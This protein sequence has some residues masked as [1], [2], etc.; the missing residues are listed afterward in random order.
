[1]ITPQQKEK[2]QAIISVFETGKADGDPSAVAV[3]SDGA[4]ISYGRHQ[5]TDGSDSLDAIVLRAIELGHPLSA[6]LKHL[7]TKLQSDG[8]TAYRSMPNEK[9]GG[10]LWDA[11]KLLRECGNHPVMLQAQNEVFDSMYWAPCAA[12]CVQMGLI[13]PLSWAVVYDSCIHSGP[14]GVARI[15]ARFA[16]MP[17]SRGGDEKAWVSAYVRERRA[18][19][20]GR[21]GVVAKT[22]YRMDAF[23]ALIRDENWDL[24]TPFRVRGVVINSNLVGDP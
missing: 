22:V 7:L 21:G 9:L 8:S 6:E 18:W 2:C 19:L 23:L 4:G 24:L 15:R 20:T 11:V 3:L 5:A 1:M 13:Y 12:Q 10:W 14:G 17:P 16:E